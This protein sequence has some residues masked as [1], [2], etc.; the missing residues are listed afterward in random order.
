MTSAK[1]LVFIDEN[2][3][4]I[5][6]IIE[7][8][9][10]GSHWFTVSGSI[11]GISQIEK[12]AKD[13]K[14]LD[15]IQIVSHGNSGALAIGS[16]ELTNHNLSHYQTSLSEIGRSLSSDGDLLIYGCNLA[17][18]ENGEKLI[19]GIAEYTLADVAA[20]TDLTGSSDLGGDS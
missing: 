11:D 6:F 5:K 19:N 17:A 2:L 16:T 3:S 20:S 4:D 10:E 14:N 18:S 13:Y 7:S 9:P 12:I 1:H 15:S 8:L